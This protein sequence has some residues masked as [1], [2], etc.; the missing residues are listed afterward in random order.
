M[1]IIFKTKKSLFSQRNTV[2]QYYLNHL[3]L[4][5]A[6][7][8]K[9][10]KQAILKNITSSS[11]SQQYIKPFYYFCLFVFCFYTWYVKGRLTILNFTG[12]ASLEESQ[13]ILNLTNWKAAVICSGRIRK[14]KYIKE[15]D[16]ENPCCNASPLRPALKSPCLLVYFWA[17]NRVGHSGVS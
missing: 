14:R 3:A 15:K 2:L 8:F 12:Q 4:A 7:L 10:N 13:W 1:S 11:V 6:L 5:T 9:Q 17:V 16:K